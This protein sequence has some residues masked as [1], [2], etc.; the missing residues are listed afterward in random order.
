MVEIDIQNKMSQG[1]FLSK[2]I[3]ITVIVA[4]LIQTAGVVW[5]ASS[6]DSKLKVQESWIQRNRNVAAEMARLEERVK[7]LQQEL[8]ELEAKVY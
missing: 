5:W 8:Q 2:Q 1:W 4:L 6:I 3:P 7:Y